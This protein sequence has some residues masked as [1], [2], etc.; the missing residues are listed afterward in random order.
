M[1]EMTWRKDPVDNLDKWFE[2]YTTRRYGSESSLA[3]QAWKT[4]IPGV[5]N[6]TIKETY[7]ILTK[8]PDTNL[9]DDLGFETKDVDAAWDWIVMAVEKDPELGLQETFR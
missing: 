1:S 4:L 8:L 3:A 5:L 2:D 9:V 7:S 6:S